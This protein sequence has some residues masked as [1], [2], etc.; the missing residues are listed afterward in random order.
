M[1]RGS[2]T[3]DKKHTRHVKTGKTDKPVL[4]MGETPV[5]VG[6]NGEAN[7]AEDRKQKLNEMKRGSLYNVGGTRVDRPNE[8]IAMARQEAR[9]AGARDVPGKTRRKKAA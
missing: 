7:Y 4:S 2:Q 5:I 6:H 1:G 9:R 8:A 3:R